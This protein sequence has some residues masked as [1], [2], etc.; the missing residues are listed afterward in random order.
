MGKQ[1]SGGG[2]GLTPAKVYLT[3]YNLAQFGLWGAVLVL[4]PR[5]LL[6][7]KGGASGVWPAVGPL[8]KLAVGACAS[9]LHVHGRT[10]RWTDPFG[11][12]SR[13]I[14]TVPNRRRV[15]GAGAHARGALPWGR[16]LR[17]LAGELFQCNCIRCTA[18]CGVSG[19]RLL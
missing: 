14:R 17:L 15:D 8:V 11:P 13:P 1:G 6:V 10:N 9:V 7:G 12:G 18:E 16:L 4:T 5:Q 19:E 3:L 2:G